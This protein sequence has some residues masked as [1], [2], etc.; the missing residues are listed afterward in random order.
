[1]LNV[2]VAE[3][4]DD[5]SAIIDDGAIVMCNHLT[6]ADVAILTFAFIN[7]GPVMQQS[8]WIGAKK[9]KYTPIGMPALWRGDFFIREVQYP[10]FLFIKF[11]HIFY[12]FNIYI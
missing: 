1:M 3:M 4:G 9:L 7:F 8:F 6:T 2:P 10:V 12:M 5:A 11:N